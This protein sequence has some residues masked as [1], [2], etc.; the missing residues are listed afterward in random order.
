MKRKKIKLILCLVLNIYLLPTVSG[1]NFNYSVGINYYENRHD[2]WEDLCTKQQIGYCT[3]LEYLD[4]NKKIY[5]IVWEYVN[6]LILKSPTDFYNS[7]K[8]ELKLYSLPLVVNLMTKPKFEMIYY[9]GIQLNIMINDG[10][11]YEKNR[12][13]VSVLNRLNASFRLTEFTR[14]NFLFTP[15]I[16]LT[17]Y[18]DDDSLGRVSF[19]GRFETGVSFKF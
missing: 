18:Q 4:K 19:G 17:N 13:G 7:P 16:L 6:R 10:F 11:I 14:L 9:S 12:L 5:G 2:C 15:A 8:K 3:S 1:Q